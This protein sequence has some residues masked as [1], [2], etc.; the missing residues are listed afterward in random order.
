MRMC[1][2]RLIAL[3]RVLRIALDKTRARVLQLL[4]RR[5]EFSPSFFAFESFR[6]L[7]AAN[8]RRS[9]SSVYYCTRSLVLH[10]TSKMPLLFYYIFVCN[11]EKSWL[12]D[13]SLTEV[14]YYPR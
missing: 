14:S 4:Q 13:Y 2:L 8:Q 10:D 5:W 9:P 12:S 3:L 6:R 1:G 7:F 11:T